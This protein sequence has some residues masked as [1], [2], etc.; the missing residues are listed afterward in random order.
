MVMCP[1]DY[2]MSPCGNENHAP[3][4]LHGLMGH[5]WHEYDKIDKDGVADSE[6]TKAQTETEIQTEVWSQS[7]TVAGLP[8]FRW[9]GWLGFGLWVLVK[10]C[11]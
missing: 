8:L 6:E 1:G 2:D 7:Q 9:L 5:N 4:P 3:L 11:L 10:V